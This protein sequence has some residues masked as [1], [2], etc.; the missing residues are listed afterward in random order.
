MLDDLCF[1]SKV[2]QTIMTALWDHATMRMHYGYTTDVYA[3]DLSWGGGFKPSAQ[4]AAT[5]GQ[6]LIY[7]TDYDNEVKSCVK[8]GNNAAG[9]LITD[10]VAEEIDA[11]K[12][13]LKKT[14]RK[15]RKRR[16]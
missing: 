10:K 16:K 15:E 2:K 7:G 1:P 14:K 3:T 4:M 13:A 11:I 6:T 8:S 12:E 9:V 5:L